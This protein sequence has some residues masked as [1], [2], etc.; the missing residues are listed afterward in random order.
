MRKMGVNTVSVPVSLKVEGLQKVISQIQGSLKGVK[1]DSSTFSKVSKELEKASS[2]LTTLEAQAA[3]GFSSQNQFT[4]AEKEIEKIEEA[5]QKTKIQLQSVDFKELKLTDDELKGFNRLNDQIKNAENE[6]K[7][8]GSIYISQLKGTKVDSVFNS[9]TGRS[10]DTSN[11][12]EA[13]KVI[14]NYLASTQADYNKAADAVDKL[15]SKMTTVNNTN[16]VLE[17]SKEQNAT[18]ETIFGSDTVSKYFR[19]NGTYKNRNNFIEYLKAN[20]VLDDATID[21]LSKE[22]AKGIITILRDA[23][24]SD[25]GVRLQSEY[26]AKNA[27]NQA[28]L[29]ARAEQQNAARE[30]YN[31]FSAAQAQYDNAIDG[32]RQSINE[33]NRELDENKERLVNSRRDTYASSGAYTELKNATKVLIAELD[34]CNAELMRQQQLMNSFTSIKNTIANFMGLTQVVQLARKAFNEA[35]K[36]IRTLDR[37]MTEIA[38]VT[39]FTQN[40]LWDQIDTYTQVAQEYGVAIEGVYEVSALYYQMG[41]NTEEVMARNIETLKMAK[42]AG[43]DYATA[44]DYKC[45]VA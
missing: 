15:N 26:G 6:L 24:M 28:E 38:V 29:R 33:L 30:V 18:L 25:V 34:S 43:L 31:T 3:S 11:F 22:N 41:L 17:A 10:I 5:I 42:I 20:Y 16:Q 8:M 7:K 1:V 14:K 40:Q 36:H 13:A 2:A 35:T 19:A 44:A 32:S 27:A 37:V 9:L 4:R 21:K 39:D 12:K 23:K 45:Y